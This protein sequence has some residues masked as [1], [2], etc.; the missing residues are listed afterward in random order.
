MN[1]SHHLEP[2]LRK[3]RLS[4]MLDTLEER[5]Q[6]AITQKHSYDDFWNGY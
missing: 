4:G 6:Q 2:K 1:I 3:L 5:T